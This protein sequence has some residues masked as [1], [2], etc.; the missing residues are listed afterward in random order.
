MMPSRSQPSHSQAVVKTPSQPVL[1]STCWQSPGLT[2]RVSLP[3]SPG[4]TPRVSLSRPDWCSEAWGDE[5]AD[6]ISDVDTNNWYAGRRVARQDVEI[7]Y[8]NSIKMSGE[9]KYIGMAAKLYWGVCVSQLP[10]DC[11]GLVA[12]SQSVLSVGSTCEP[13]QPASQQG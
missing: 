4:L 2:P 1:I 7:S 8:V 12:M 10:G 9:M 3:H 5:E 13:G 6:N 11:V